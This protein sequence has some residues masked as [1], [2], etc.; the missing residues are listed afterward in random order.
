MSA[1]RF[2]R[3]GRSRARHSNNACTSGQRITTPAAI[4]NLFLWLDANAGITKDVGNKVSAWADQSGALNNFAQATAANQPLWVAAQLNGLPIVRGDGL[5][6]FMASAS[7]AAQAALSVF[8]VAKNPDLVL[9][10]LIAFGSNTKAIVRG[11]TTNTWK[12]YNSPETEI[13]PDTPVQFRA[14]GAT[15]GSSTLGAWNVG[16]SMTPSSWS[17]DDLAEVIVYNRALSGSEY[18]SVLAYLKAKYAL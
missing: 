2:S 18:M 5:A 7:I 17:N 6:T 4:P 9:K 8:C 11:V 14:F 10:Y 3:R 15:V 13:A 12:W 1:Q 16:A